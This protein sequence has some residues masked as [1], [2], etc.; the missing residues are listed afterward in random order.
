MN[1]N[2]RP[3]TINT[4]QTLILRPAKNLCAS[5]KSQYS[6]IEKGYSAISQSR[7]IWC[8]YSFV[9]KCTMNPKSRCCD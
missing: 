4:S 2:I 8:C 7:I 6:Y 1:M 5:L 9:C 3:S